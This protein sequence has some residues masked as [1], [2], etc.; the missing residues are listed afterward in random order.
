MKKHIIVLVFALLL[1][2]S[3]T[4]CSSTGVIAPEATDAAP[5]LPLS[6]V[7]TITEPPVI[8]TPAATTPSDAQ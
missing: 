2:L 6:T 7:S 5:T 8:V 3:L 4:A 1:C